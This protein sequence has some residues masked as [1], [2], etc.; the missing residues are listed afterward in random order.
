MRKKL[1]S[2]IVHP[3]YDVQAVEWRRGLTARGEFERDI[4]RESKVARIQVR[5]NGVK[6]EFLI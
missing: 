1:I 4:L 6:F 2:S 3:R 5:K